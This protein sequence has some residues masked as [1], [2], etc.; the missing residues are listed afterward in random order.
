MANNEV[1]LR[2]GADATGLQNGLRQSSTAVSSFGTKARATIAR[3]GGSMRGLADS[4][5][6]PFNSLVL[7]G[8]LGMAV[9][10]VGDLSESLMYYGFAAKK[11][12]ADTKVFRESLHKTAIETGVAAN[13]ILNGVS[14]IGEITGQFDFAEDMGGILAKAAKASGA[15]VED[16]ANVAS[17]L[18]VTMGLTADEVAKFF[19]SLIIQGDQGSYTLQKF[20][21]EGKALL[22]A[23]STHGIKTADQFASFGA[24][25]QVMNAQIKSEAELT[26]SVS[27]LF[28]ELVSKAKDLNKIGVHVFDKNKEFNDFDFIMRQ[29]MEKTDGDLQKLGKL[30]G[31][32][33]IKALQPI[34]SEYKN[35]WKTVETITKSGQEGMANTKVLDERFQKT[36]N[37]FNSNVDKMKAVALQFADTNLT[38]PVEQLTTALGFLSRHQGIVTAGFKMM[39][40]AAAALGMVKIGGLVKDVA[41]L[42]R[43]IKGIWSKNGG[44]GASAAGTGVSALDASVQKV[45]VVNMRSGFG[46]GSDYMDDDAPMYQPATQK[47]A[48]AMESTT[49]EVGRFRQGLST[50]RAGLNKF[51]SS[52][53]GGTLM[54]AATGWA[55]N[56]IYNFGQAFMEWRNVVADVEANSRAMVDR[57]QTEFEKRYG[58]EAARW[59]KKHGDTLLEIQKEENSFLPSQKKLD[60]LYGDLRLYNQLTK[61]AVAAQK[62]DKMMS[63]QEYMQALNQNIIINVDSNG[64]AVV[65]TDKGKPPKVSGRKT[66]PGWGA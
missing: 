61:N 41:G 50:A 28:S 18:K 2:I 51:G 9:K 26:T 23:T 27:T 21:A 42:A 48:Q 8:G 57:N 40:V 13:E 63:P 22:A 29:L 66:T 17:S 46:G 12:D 44:A 65:E 14:K 64:K 7:G 30:F 25:L 59:S 62:G 52:V 54:T 11:S 5:V 35:G 15:S 4:L 58:P 1:T 47:A 56:Q 6:T 32:S 3:V 16:L 60:K 53:I 39:A 10:N 49:K 38:G 19:N 36:A 20:A 43:D 37:D 31:A 34:I 55:M 45:F 33:S 24:Y